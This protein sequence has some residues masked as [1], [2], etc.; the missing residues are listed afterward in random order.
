M[1][2]QNIDMDTAAKEHW[3]H[4]HTQRH[5]ATLRFHGEGWRV[6][7]GKT[8]ISTNLKHKLLDH[9]AGK[10]AKAYWSGKTCFRDIDVNL[11]D[12]K[13]IAKVVQG[14]TIS[15]RRW[16]AKFTTGFCAMGLRMTQM[17]KWPTADCPRCGQPNEDTDHI[18]QCPNIESQKLWDSAVQQL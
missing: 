16:T 7:L 14:Q 3:Q 8:K 11:V 4:H 2:Q 13:T 15:M 6:F 10:A 9:T 12:W 17:K 1:E 18:L 5:S